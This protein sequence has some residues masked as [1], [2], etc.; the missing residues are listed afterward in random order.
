MPSRP[1]IRALF[2]LLSF[3]GS[4]RADDTPASKLLAD[5]G[6]K[7]LGSYWVLP[8]EQ[9]LQDRLKSIA[10][11]QRDLSQAL[12]LREDYDK[13][14]EAKRAALQGAIAEHRRLTYLA[15]QAEKRKDFNAITSRQAALSNQIDMMVSYLNDPAPSAHIT[16][17]IGE[18]G[19]ALYGEV[20]A[21]RQLVDD[22]TERYE[23]LAGDE[24]VQAAI[25]ELAAQGGRKIN[26]GPRRVFAKNIAE[27]ER[28]ESAIQTEDIKLR[29]DHGVYWVEVVLNGT[30]RSEMVFDTGASLLLL[31]TALA[32]RAG[33]TPTDSD[34][35]V[36]M[37]VADGRTV[38]GRLVFLK[39]VRVGG[40]EE[41][42]V[43]A[44]VLPPE[45]GDAEPLLGGSF[46]RNYAI[47]MN[48]A[49]G[50]LT[51][52]KAKAPTP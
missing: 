23:Q 34:P 15:M 37:Q 12:K 18:A 16:R 13:D 14:R 29:A 42:N 2:C 21:L 4:A 19:D 50:T 36:P 28:F 43:E 30:T 11:L 25:A 5:R 41:Q 3:A 10:P 26:L 46:L 22:A 51:L 45:L 1:C 6:L 24:A 40:F 32:T 49:A 27:L 20:H 35:V 17:R 7:K 44:A 47:R 39:S 38:E 48:Q 9:E 8:A 31:S 52:T 33:V